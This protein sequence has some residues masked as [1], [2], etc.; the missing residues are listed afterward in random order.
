MLKQIQHEMFDP[1]T[2]KSP[3]LAT[4]MDLAVQSL[5]REKVTIQRPQQ[6]QPSGSV[7]APTNKEWHDKLEAILNSG[8]EMT[9]NAVIPNIEVFFERL[10]PVR[11]KRAS[12]E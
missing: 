1:A 9:I 4:L 11:R 2:G 8:D 7:Y 10:K 12:G 5:A 6:P 3:T